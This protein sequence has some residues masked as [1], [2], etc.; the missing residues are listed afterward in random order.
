M[1]HQG[2]KVNCDPH[3][4]VGLYAQGHEANPTEGAHVPDAEPSTS[5]DDVDPITARTGLSPAMR[6][7]RAQLAAHARWAK[8]ADRLA[9]T[10]PARA[11]MMRQFEDEV[12][13]ERKLPP[14]L[15]AK[16]AENARKAQL[17]R[18]SLKGVKARQAKAK[19]RKAT[20]EGG[21]GAA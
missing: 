17:L 1:T 2:T 8:E 4:P 19:A 16:M 6:R 11:A 20:N 5:D 9:A 7:K 14:V 15:R 13:P 10:A 18:M 3:Q 12:D 21:E